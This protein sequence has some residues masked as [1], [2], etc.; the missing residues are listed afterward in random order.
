M[1]EDCERVAARMNDAKYAQLFEAWSIEDQIVSGGE[2][3]DVEALIQF[4]APADEGVLRE[5]REFTG[6]EIDQA[7]CSSHTAAL[8][9]DVKPDV[10]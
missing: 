8:S 7:G 5:E 10:V 1:S 9:G 4:Q 2:S 3:A 6:N